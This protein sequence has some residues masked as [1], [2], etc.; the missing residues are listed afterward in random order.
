MQFLADES[1]DFAAV[2]ALRE[3]GHDV[4]AVA[5]FSARVAALPK[6]G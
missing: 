4:L 1:R 6:V 3:A 5:E 2:R